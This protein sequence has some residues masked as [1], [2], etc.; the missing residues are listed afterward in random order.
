[1]S[2]GEIQ[3]F[4]CLWDFRAS[5]PGQREARQR[6]AQQGGETEKKSDG[7]VGEKQKDGGND[8]M[9]GSSNDDVG[10]KAEPVEADGKKAWADVVDGEDEDNG[11]QVGEKPDEPVEVDG[12]EKQ[13]NED[14][15]VEVE[16]EEEVVGEKKA[17]PEAKAKKPPRGP[18][19]YRR[20]SAKP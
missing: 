17:K 4:V 8:N 14:E 19:F 1:L 3:G 16:G 5:R 13:E 6:Q 15:P 2:S 9:P 10:K 18:D 7:H 20:R 11:Q 12:E